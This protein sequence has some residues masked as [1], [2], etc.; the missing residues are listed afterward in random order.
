MVGMYQAAPNFGATSTCRSAFARSTVPTMLKSQTRASATDHLARRAMI[1][2]SGE[3][4]R[5]Q[6]TVGRGA[7]ELRRQRLIDHTG[8]EEHQS[9]VAKRVRQAQPQ[10]SLVLR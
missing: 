8:H 7:G 10:E 6:V 5:D 2:N 3:Y 9:N 4:T 1:A